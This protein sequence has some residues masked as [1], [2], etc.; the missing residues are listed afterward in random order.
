LIRS[1]LTLNISFFS[2]LERDFDFYSGTSHV[3]CQVYGKD[4]VDHCVRTK[5]VKI[6]PPPTLKGCEALRLEI[7]KGYSDPKAAVARAWMILYSSK[8]V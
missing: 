4:A 7:A 8:T 3:V 5:D 2:L 1:C 6:T